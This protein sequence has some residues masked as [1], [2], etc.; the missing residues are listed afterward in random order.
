MQKAKYLFSLIIT[1]GWL[2]LVSSHLNSQ[3]VSARFTTSAYTWEQQEIDSSKANHLRF[4]QLAQLSLGNL[5]LPNLSFHT[6]VQFSN[7]FAEKAADDPRWWIYNCYFDLKNVAKA[8]DIGLGR[9]R[10]YAGVGYGTV[11]GLQLQYHLKDYF[12]IKFYVGTLAPIAK[13]TEVRDFNGDNLTY[14]FHL[15]S[16]KLKK[17]HIGLSYARQSVEPIKYSSPGSFTGTFRLDHPVSARQKE[18]IGLDVGSQINNKLRLNGRLDFNLLAQNVKRGEFGGRYQINRN[19]ELGLDYIYRTPFID[20]NSIFSVFVLNPNQE[21][22]FQGRYRWNEYQFFVN[23]S[24]VIFDG[25]NNQRLGVGCSWKSLYLGY[26]R[27]AG[28]GGDSDGL[29]LNFNYPLMDKL[30]VTLGSNFASYKLSEFSKEKD[31]AI[32]GVLGI[33]YVPVK[34]L[35]LQAEAQVLNNKIFSRDVRFFF[36]GSYA[37]FQRL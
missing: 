32:A 29:T 20:Q 35:S 34:N 23:A 18:L 3:T 5:G 26:N 22:A 25:D 19:F 2:I 30:N 8:I 13:S 21:I 10:I 15:T 27:R 4:Y 28:Y 12:K 37:L 7:D 16:A 9:Q 6:Y 11:D 36:R 33:N 31:Q 1:S 17:V 14:G 24:N